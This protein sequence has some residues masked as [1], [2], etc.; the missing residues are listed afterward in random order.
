MQ[1]KKDTKE[2]RNKQL[3]LGLKSPIRNFF[4]RI[5]SRILARLS[6]FESNKFINDPF[7]WFFSSIMSVGS[8]AQLFFVTDNIGRVPEIIPIFRSTSI[9]QLML[10]PKL[11]LFFI[12]VI[13]LL[14][15]IVT[16]RRSKS[17]YFKNA[18]LSHFSMFLSSIVIS[19]LSIHLIKILIPYV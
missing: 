9:P 18:S 5:K 7:V 14:I 16:F 19:V 4:T 3:E 1:K 17:D 6:F 12:P 13:S 11:F 8:F 15:F 10:V 2:K